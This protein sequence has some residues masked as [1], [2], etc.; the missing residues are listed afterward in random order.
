MRYVNHKLPSVFF[1]LMFPMFF[2][3]MTPLAR[4]FVEVRVIRA[5]MRVTIII[6]IRI[7][8]TNRAP[9]Y[10]EGDNQDNC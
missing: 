9:E 4:V 1:A 2:A 8:E 10:G 5:I 7:P 6:G 3:F